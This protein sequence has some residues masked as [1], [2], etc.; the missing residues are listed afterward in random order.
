MVLKNNVNMT[1]YFDRLLNLKYTERN[2]SFMEINNTKEAAVLGGKWNKPNASFYDNLIKEKNYQSLINEAFL[3]HGKVSKDT[4][5]SSSGCKYPHHVIKDGKLVVS[6]AG[7]RAAYSRARQ[8]GVYHGKVKTHLQKHM[9]ELGILKEQQTIKENFEFIESVINDYFGTNLTEGAIVESKSSKDPTV[10]FDVENITP[11]NAKLYEKALPSIKEMWDFP[12]ENC[13]QKVWIDPDNADT[14][15]CIQVVKFKSEKYKGNDNLIR[16]FEVAPKYRRKGIGTVILK[17]AVKSMGGEVLG[18]LKSNTNA[19]NLYKKLGFTVYDE[20]ETVYAMRAPKHFTESASSPV[21]YHTSQIQGLKILQPEYNNRKDEDHLN[22][23]NLYFSPD[24]KFSACFGCDWISIGNHPTG[25]LGF[26]NGKL[27]FSLSPKVDQSKPCS[28]YTV[29]ADDYNMIN[30]NE[31]IIG[32]PVRVISEE[33]FDSFSQMAAT[34]G[35]HIDTIKSSDVDSS[36]L[37]P[38]VKDIVDKMNS[39][40]RARICDPS[41]GEYADSDNVIYRDTMHVGEYG[42]FI[43]VYN[44]TDCPAFIVIGLDKQVQHT[45]LAVALVKNMLINVDTRPITWECDPDNTASIKL[46]EKCG[47]IFKEKVTDHGREQLIYELSG[48]KL[49]NESVSYEF[50]PGYIDPT[51]RF[52]E[53]HVFTDDDITKV[54]TDIRTHKYFSE[55]VDPKWKKRLVDAAKSH[56]F[57]D[58]TGI[59]VD[60]SSSLDPLYFDYFYYVAEVAYEMIRDGDVGLMMKDYK[61][62]THQTIGKDINAFGDTDDNNSL[63]GYLSSI[64]Y[65]LEYDND[66]D[67]ALNIIENSIINNNENPVYICRYIDENTQSVLQEELSNLEQL[68]T[69]KSSEF[70][71]NESFSKIKGYVPLLH[72]VIEEESVLCNILVEEID[73]CVNAFRSLASSYKDEIQVNESKIFN[74]PDI[75]YNKD[76]FDKGLT[77]ICFITGL[78][79]S[80]KSTMAVNMANGK[81]NVEWIMLDDLL[82]VKKHFTMKNLQEYGDLIY[83][84]FKG[85]GKK[86]YIDDKELGKKFDGEYDGHY[87]DQMYPEFVH[88]A[89]E[90]AKKHKNK[91]Y[92]LEGVWLFCVNGE[93]NPHPEERG[94]PWFDPKEFKPYALYVKGTSILVSYIR[95]AKRDS[96]DAGKWY[97][98]MKVFVKNVFSL[99][100]LK[101]YLQDEKNVNRFRNYFKPLSTKPI[102]ESYIEDQLNWIAEYTNNES[103]RNS[104]I[105]E[106]QRMDEEDLDWVLNAFMEADN[107]IDESENDKHTQQESMPK[108]TDKAEA[109]KNGANRKKL[110]IAFIE[111]CKKY[112]NKNTFGSHFDK[113][114]FNVTYPFVPD[115]M[116]YFYRLA[117]PTICVLSGDLTF[118]Q[119]SELRKI[120]SVHNN[121]ANQMIFAAAGDDSLRVFNKADKKV[122]KATLDEKT[123]KIVLGN[124]LANTFDLYIQNMIKEGDFLNAPPEVNK[125]DT[126][127]QQSNQ[128][129]DESE[130]DKPEQNEADTSETKEADNNGNNQ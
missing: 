63:Y 100:R 48:D 125:P 127:S 88:Y 36:K 85:P 25:K 6:E 105:M 33:K 120:N 44:L 37:Y 39:D 21:L 18:V 55:H 118:F 119:L 8:M 68:I 69:D 28:I 95:A 19:I 7:V 66:L 10:L 98:K 64:S 77:N 102:Q 112:N 84:F 51:Q 92:I 107:S 56:K 9:R 74:E 61:L 123:K 101:W 122:Y 115:E 117:D 110:Y 1:F 75:Y 43:D 3:I 59:R 124:A 30:S 47:F 29:Q 38:D 93:N 32:H 14:V 76:K 5:Y 108:Q 27:H 96:A 42:G 17:Y 103:F 87:E 116:R 54:L 60:K 80:G 81:K 83:S 91:K 40:D 13:N 109:N 50:A 23:S 106:E 52:I 126:N 130:N 24:K 65:S 67:T 16:A 94:K 114:V 22:E 12:K 78:S 41:T 11:E 97:S 129:T 104:A 128:S 20:D 49:M 121:L 4:T 2:I 62:E 82:C 99:K 31:A 45:G 113:D 46:A 58:H 34:L 111:W 73:S 15:G 53:N 71:S 90:W 57:T 79:G 35:I 86:W 89:M 70:K 26:N 72:K